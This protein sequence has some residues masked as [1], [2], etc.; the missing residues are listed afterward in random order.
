M[1]K[2]TVAVTEKQVLDADLLV[3]H[4]LEKLVREE[5]INLATYNKAKGK[6]RIDDRK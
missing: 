4:L 3:A 2:V 1:K 6:V 5:I